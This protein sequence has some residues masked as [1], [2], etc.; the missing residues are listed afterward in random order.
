MESEE[1]DRTSEQELEK[2]ETE[3]EL[4]RAKRLPEDPNSPG[5]AAEMAGLGPK[6]AD[7]PPPS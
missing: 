4:E 3:R 7:D 6:D 2:T 1:R 5:Y